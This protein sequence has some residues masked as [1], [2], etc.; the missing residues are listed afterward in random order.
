MTQRDLVPVPLLLWMT[1]SLRTVSCVRSLSRE[2]GRGDEVHS[3][4]RLLTLMGHSVMAACRA[5]TMQ[6]HCQSHSACQQW[7]AAHEQHTGSTYPVGR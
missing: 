1:S 3:F 2:Q 7:Q 4:F 6:C 5:C